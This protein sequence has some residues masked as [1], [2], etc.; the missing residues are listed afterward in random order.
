M[1]QL[2]QNIDWSD[3]FSFRWELDIPDMVYSSIVSQHRKKSDY[4]EPLMKWYLTNHPAPSWTHVMRALYDVGEHTVLEI[5]RRQLPHLK[6]RS[7]MHFF[8]S[9]I[10][11]GI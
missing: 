10:E 2:L 11:Q 4:H 3:A 6:G 5:L 8:M 9:M 7:G 1:T